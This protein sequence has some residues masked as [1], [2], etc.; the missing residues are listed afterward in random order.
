[1]QRDPPHVLILCGGR[2]LGADAALAEHLGWTPSELAAL[3]RGALVQ[4]DEQARLEQLAPGEPGVLT[5]SR[6]D[7]GRL[8]LDVEVSRVELGA[9]AG[10]VVTGHPRH[11]RG[12]VEAPGQ[13]LRILVVDDEP[14]IGAVI[15]AL[16]HDHRVHACGGEEALDA[17]GEGWDIVLCDL[18]MPRVS[19]QQVFDHALRAHPDA[20][21]GFVFLTGGA[22]SPEE[23]RFLATCGR[24]VLT[25]PFR[26]AQLR[27]IIDRLCARAP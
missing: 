10:L 19:G 11:H 13:R 27:E 24:P 1:M 6:R 7:G 2:A 22:T 12:E 17:L 18:M 16:L 3:A 5:L 8:S 21:R 25:K 23:E 20:V 9:R 26:I 15:S 4:P 14:E